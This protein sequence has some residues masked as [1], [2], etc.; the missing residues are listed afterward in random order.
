MKSAEAS[1]KT[2]KGR[3]H[4][5]QLQ[6]EVDVDLSAG[7]TR[8]NC[9]LCTKLGATGV[10]VKPAAFRALSDE[11]TLGQYGNPV[12]TRFFC[13][14]CSIYAYGRGHLAELGGD[15]VSVN[16]NTLDDIEHAELE[17]SHWDGR[18]D[19]W[20]AGT[21]KVPWPSLRRED[22]AELDRVVA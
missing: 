4:C 11:K 12:A 8:C 3:C 16:V 1:I 21:R 18:H 17:V 13:P 20:Y 15:F 19:N 5:R 9:T 14:K 2:Y 7:V 22:P 6:F 10:I